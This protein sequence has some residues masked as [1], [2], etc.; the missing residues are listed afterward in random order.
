MLWIKLD[1]EGALYRQL[2]RALRSAIL[3]GRLGPEERLPSTRAFA[4]ELGLSRN[5]VLQAMEQ[6]IAEGYATGRVGSGTYVAGVLPRPLPIPDSATTGISPGTEAPLRLSAMAER[7]SQ[8][9]P[10]GRATWSPFQEVLPYD[11]RYGEPSY[12][13]LPIDTWSLLLGRRARRL[14]T[15]RLAYQAPGGASELREALVGYLARA[16]GVVCSADQVIIVNGSQ[17]AVDLTARLLVNPGD[18]VVIE[19]P[20]YTGFSFCLHAVGADLVP[21]TVDD[22]GLRTQ[23]LEE[24][25][26]ARL[27]CV[28]PAHQYPLGSV[29]SL[30]R[31]LALIDWAVRR[32]AYIL[33]DDY[34]GEFRYDAKP[35][36]S[37]QSLD[38]SGR[39]IYA[40]TA[41][42]VLFPALRI[43]W[44]VA[45]PALAPYYINAKAL[46][47][48]GTPSLAQLALADF[49][50][51]GH[52]ERHA[53]RARIQTGK[54]RAALLEI[55]QQELS[56]RAKLV[57]ASAGLHVL[58]QL[59]NLD[60]REVSRLRQ[61]CRERGVGVYPAAPYYSRP[62]AHAELLLGY[63]AMEEDK[64]REGIRRLRQALDSL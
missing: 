15:R 31:R 45:P 33:E 48:T 43:G 26:N 57:G 42:K 20:H 3:E 2:Y 39:V 16:R 38:R 23:D 36:E 41:S 6:L 8:L 44:V 62:P 4:A 61:A 1:G 30:Q 13:D 29:M 35:I 34:D 14:S 56:G 25:E 11:F 64:I 63:A 18:P 51:E 52:L 55:V 46:A 24:V 49:I 59:P 9:V 5:T 21:I 22:Y 47:D 60:A 19:E 54:R 53:R 12:A 17:Q 58:L 50:A 32:D 40:G 27:V 28:T 10:P 7:L 37:L